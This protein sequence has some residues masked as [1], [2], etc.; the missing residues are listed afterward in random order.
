MFEESRQIPSGSELRS[1]VCIIGGGPVAIAM[2]LRLAKAGSEVL[3]LPGG[4]W[5]EEADDRD[6]YRGFV[7]PAGS[8]EPLE[9]NRR[10]VWGGTGTVWGGRC[11]PFD[12]IDYENRPWIPHSGWPIARAEAEQCLKDALEFCEAGSGSFEVG[13]VFPDSPTAILPGF[14]N[15]K[16]ST[17]NLE[18][19]SPPTNFGRRHRKD[20]QLSQ[21]IR[22]L[23]HG[24]ATHLQLHR[25][26]NRLEHVQAAAQPGHRFRIRSSAYVLACGGLENPRL[27]LASRNIQKE[28]IGNRF[29][30]VGR[31]YQSHLFG[32]CGHAILKNP[33]SMVYDFEKDADGVYCRRRFWLTAEA[34]KEHQIGN[35]VGFFFRDLSDAAMHR[36]PV[37]SSVFLAK[38]LLRASSR[39][40]P[41]LSRLWREQGDLLREHF[42]TILAQAP[43][44]GPHLFRLVAGRFFG[45]RRLPFFLPP[46][47]QGRFPLFYQTEHTP[48]PESR[49]L[50]SC[51]QKDDLG[52]PRLLVKI[53]FGHRDFQSVKIF[54]REFQNRLRA[55]GL[56]EFHYDEETLAAQLENRRSGFNSNAHHIGTTRMASRPEHGVVDTQGRIHGVANLFV[57][58]SSV[59]P[60]SSHANPTLLALALALRQARLLG[61]I[62]HGL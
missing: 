30:Q 6:R 20:I 45:K 14:E 34:Q 38:S 26:G 4:G 41:G 32:V 57:A 59:F 61:Q 8:H 5:R 9:E 16:W 62:V 17:R 10:R 25:N 31:Y 42:A 37:T 36:D 51:D 3:L 40:R 60:T 58:G 27:L 49:V 24:Q 43:S 23:L 12:T 7:D 28:G 39:G 22:V 19:W 56:G 50:L 54:H 47:R 53:R 46:V 21:K 48:D 33:H 18:R 13:K 15:E 44:A 29:D 2:A 11:V 52:V 1:D 55:T 35:A